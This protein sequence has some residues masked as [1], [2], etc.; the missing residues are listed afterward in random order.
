[1]KLKSHNG[2]FIDDFCSLL[3]RNRALK[4]RDV[5]AL[6]KAFA[7]R[8]DL[9]FEEFLIDE[10]VISREDLLKALSE[11]YN[12]TALDVIGLFF[13]HHLVIMFPKDVLMRYNFIP[14]MKD[15]DVLAVIAG[16]PLDPNLSEIIGKFVSYDVEI[17]VGFF[18]DIQDEIEEFYDK[19]VAEV[20]IPEER[21]QEKD[22]RESLEE[23]IRE[24]DRTLR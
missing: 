6:K 16:D 12:M 18:R 20:D 2:N 7:N 4:D 13:D 3:Q 5:S 11:Y 14:Y 10:N 15:G 9:T 17:Y 21:M 1:M 24:V 8:S 22:R 19:S 23:A